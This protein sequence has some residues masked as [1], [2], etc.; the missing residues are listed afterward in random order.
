MFNDN[1]SIC[2]PYGGYN[3][4]TLNIVK[5]LKVKFA[6]TT[7]VGNLNINNLNRI[8]EICRYDCNDF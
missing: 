2:Y 4:N 6:V 7:V 3:N 1:L 8:Y 5:N